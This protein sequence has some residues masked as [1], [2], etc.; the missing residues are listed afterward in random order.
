M[1]KISFA[2]AKL[3]N[4]SY[5][6]DQDIHEESL[7]INFESNYSDDDDHKFIIRFYVDITSQN[8]TSIAL[9]YGGLFETDT[10]I[11]EEFKNG[12]FST[13]N[14][15]AIV[16]P[17]LRSFLNTITLNAG[18]VPITLPTVNFQALANAESKKA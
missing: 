15:P 17:Y 14:A 8:G 6:A 16:Y 1:E 9:E 4:L 3:L 12:P 2:G 13:V 18:D 7:S 5:Q 11:T 10:P